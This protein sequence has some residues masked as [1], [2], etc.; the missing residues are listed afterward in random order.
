MKK[1]KQKFRFKSCRRNKHIPLNT[2]VVPNDTPFLLPRK[3]TN[4]TSI[5]LNFQTDCA[6]IFGESNQQ[7]LAKSGH[8]V[9]PISPHNK[10]LNDVT[11]C[12]KF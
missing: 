3:A 7:I 5:I 10:V 1:T 11:K 6:V 2:D 9:T 8:C 12:D 4:G